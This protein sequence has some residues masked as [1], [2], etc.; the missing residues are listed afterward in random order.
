MCRTIKK[1]AYNSGHVD[2]PDDPFFL[3]INLKVNKNLVCLNKI[4][5]L[6]YKY[7]RKELLG[8]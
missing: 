2:N 6:L 3:A 7:F 5:N 1:T 4:K 8:P